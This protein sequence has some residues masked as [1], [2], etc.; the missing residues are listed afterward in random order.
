MME[1]RYL[2]WLTVFFALPV[3]VLW[4]RYTSTVRR[5]L[6]VIG[7]AAAGSAFIA[8]PWDI[9]ALHDGV[10]VFNDAALLGV[11]LYGIPVDELGWFA[12]YPMLVATVTVLLYRREVE[13]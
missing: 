12:L 3:T 5:Y 2:A 8:I 9:L 11:K 13:A 7:F 4:L 6:P 10:W 1:Y